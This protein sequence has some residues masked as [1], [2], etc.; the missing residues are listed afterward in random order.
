MFGECGRRGIGVVEKGNLDD[1]DGRRWGH[2]LDTGKESDLHIAYGDAVMF[3]GE[4]V[5]MPICWV[6][7]DLEERCGYLIGHDVRNGWFLSGYIQA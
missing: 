7:L 4:R 5:A 3:V 1:G 6:V 2:R